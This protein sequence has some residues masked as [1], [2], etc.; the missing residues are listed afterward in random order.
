MHKDPLPVATTLRAAAQIVGDQLADTQITVGNQVEILEAI[1]A[2]GEATDGPHGQ[3][4]ECL[5]LIGEDGRCRECG[6]L[7]AWG[8][9]RGTVHK[10]GPGCL[11]AIPLYGTFAYLRWA[12][13]HPEGVPVLGNV[14]VRRRLRRRPVGDPSTNGHD[15]GR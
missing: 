10:E 12:V 1:H 8:M 2:L 15:P 13:R 5:G 7:A 9:W 4:A 6:R 3:I 14:L 11:T